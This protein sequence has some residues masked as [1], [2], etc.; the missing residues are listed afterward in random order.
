MSHGCLLGSVSVPTR[1]IRLYS[2]EAAGSFRRRADNNELFRPA[3]HAPQHADRRPSSG[4]RPAAAG[5]WHRRAGAAGCGPAGGLMPGR[6]RAAVGAAGLHRPAD[7]GA[8]GRISPA[9][10][11]PSI[12]ATAPALPGRGRGHAGDR[13]RA[14]WLVTMYRFPGQR[15]FKWALV[16]PLAMPAY[17][18]AYAY[19]DFLQVT[20]PVQTAARPHRLGLARLL[21]PQRPLARRRRLRADR[22]AL[23]L[24]S[25]C[26]PAPP[27]P[28][29]RS[30][31]WRS[32][33]RW[34]ARRSG[35]PPRRPAAGPA[36]D[37]GRR[38]AS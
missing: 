27:S 36:G 30:A 11:W 5:P 6:G 38:G 18:L 32:A 3:M 20:G 22:G 17:V 15:L 28:S 2:A 31:P 23:P 7:A 16:L 34:A 10:S 33:A 12:C 19:T 37:R 35:V 1:P 25:T 26:S 9:P 8:C 14:G 24:T 4:R 29:S 13:G 21:V